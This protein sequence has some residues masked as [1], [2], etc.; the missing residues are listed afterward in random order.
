VT[1]A[2]LLLAVAAAG[3]VACARPARFADRAILWRDPDD[4]PVPLPKR[5]P[6]T[7]DGRIWPGANNA[8]FRPAERLFT[9]D[10]GLEAAN[11][12]ALDEVPTSS[13]YE[14]PRRDPEHPNAPPRALSAE[15]MLRGA[16]TEE[17][18]QP[19][20]VI[21]STLGGGSAVGFVVEDATGR[22]FALKLDPAG[23]A[24]LVTGP[25]AVA[26]R[27]AWASGW[28]VP[29]DDLI[30]LSR[31][32]LRVRPGA[33]KLTSYGRHVPLAEGELEALL[34][35][36]V[37]NADGRYRAVASR[38]IAG[39]IL[40]P[41][42]WRGR[43][44]SDANDRYAHENR[45]DLRGFG[46]FAAWV[47]DVDVIE[48]N[49][50]DSYVGEPG[51]GHVLHYQ[52]DVGGS[53]GTFS[54]RQAHYWMGD[55]SYFQPGRII[56]S[57]L[58]AGFVPYRWEDRGWQRRRRA[59]LEEYPEFGGYSAHHFDPRAWRPIVDIPAFVRQTRRDRYWGAKRIAAF[60]REEL[61][62][63]VAAGG[64]RPQAANYLAE[65]LWLRRVR[66]ARDAFAETAA[67]DHVAVVGE[68][69]C[70]VDLWVRAALGGGDATEYRARQDRRDLGWVRGAAPDGSV[71]V[72]LP[73]S[74]DGYRVVTL[75]ARRPGERHFGPGVDVHLAIHGGRARVIGL[76]R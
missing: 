59:L 17:V 73:G 31:D 74:D 52:L 46:V 32:Q 6:P 26:T 40:G 33:T 66:I 27:L 48:N 24:G 47:D 38:W 69:L 11:V 19:P 3:L 9:V 65:T 2:A 53:F 28:R 45:R 25:D 10:Y 62:A 16:R 64:Y 34:G 29:A 21:D 44:P 12:N 63:A 36:C 41:M 49:T 55:Q 42:S 58:T 7:G 20:F 8:I 39:H 57:F 50:L 35:R 37:R 54:G 22:R 71:C 18:A 13:W 51:R 70:F 60:S 14:D 67:L 56:G 4:A 5:R 15:A 30:E 75:A 72:S 23:H 61:Q 1:R 43:D 68:R 76:V